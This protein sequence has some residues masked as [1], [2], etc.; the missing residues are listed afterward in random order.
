MKQIIA[1]VIL[2]LAF[3]EIVALAQ[4]DKIFCAEIK[5]NASHGLIYVNEPA[6]INV[7]VGEAFKKNKIEYLWTVSGGK[8]TRGQ[9]T[10]AIEV[11]PSSEEENYNIAVSVKLNGLPENCFDT[12]THT[13]AVARRTMDIWFD[14]FGELPKNDLYARLESFFA[15]IKNNP[16][17]Q[18]LIAL[19]FDKTETRAEK[20]K[21][22]NEI[23]DY[24]KR[25][26]FDKSQLKFLISETDGKN[27]TLYIVPQGAKLAQAV[28]ES[29][30]PNIIKG[31][32]I[33]R[34]I[35]ELFPKK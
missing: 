10:P 3:S 20:I 34:K 29:V 25:S 35:K 11:T 24:V 13:F 14:K 23:L 30:L 33:E 12:S 28:S 9:R 21:R 6:R 18:G 7:E 8:I 22:L 16:A 19:E 4:T 26:K 31:E 15:A 17:A 32:E 1:G 2:I 27:T 5:F